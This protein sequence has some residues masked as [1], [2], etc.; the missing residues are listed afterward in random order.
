MS[1]V[2]VIVAAATADV[3]SVA[4]AVVVAAAVSA[5]ERASCQQTLVA[6]VVEQQNARVE[7]GDKPI[8]RVSYYMSNG[9]ANALVTILCF[10]KELS[11]F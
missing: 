7:A 3:V 10:A 5:G 1:A 6:A 9:F 4:A 8:H 11:P 2:A